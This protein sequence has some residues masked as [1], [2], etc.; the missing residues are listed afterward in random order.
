MQFDFV[1]ETGTIPKNN[2]WQ[3]MIYNGLLK[4]S[5]VL[6]FGVAFENIPE[7]LDYNLVLKYHATVF[8]IYPFL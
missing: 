2:E 4:A 6:K 8:A 5:V 7:F 3:A 1:S